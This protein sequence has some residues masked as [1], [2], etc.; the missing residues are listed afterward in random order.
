LSVEKESEFACVM[1]AIEP[2]KREAHIATAKHLFDSVKE[3]QE[4]PSGYAFRLPNDA[5]LL[6]K[7]AEFISLER[8]CC[9]F[10]GFTVKVEP[11][12]GAVWLQLIGREGI[13][14]FIRAEIG[15]FLGESVSF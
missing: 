12:G 1:D 7:I 14:Q 6:L 10:F 3:I 13:K 2:D 8:L 4:L 5:E 15:E 11:E 9:P